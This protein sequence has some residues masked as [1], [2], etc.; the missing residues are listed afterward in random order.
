MDGG[1]PRRN[2][3][4]RVK[5]LLL[6]SMSIFL[7][8]VS[9]CEA[10]EIIADPHITFLQIPGDS[11]GEVSLSVRTHPGRSYQW[12]LEGPGRLIGDTGNPAI[13]YVAPSVLDDTEAAA[14]IRITVAD[15][16]GKKTTDSFPIRLHGSFKPEPVP[17]PFNPI[18]DLLEKAEAA[19]KKKRFTTPESVS[20]FSYYRKVLDEDPEN[21]EA[22]KGIEQ[23]LA[24]YERRIRSAS[25]PSRAALFFNRYKMVADYHSGVSSEPQ[26]KKKMPALIP[27]TNPPEQIPD[28]KRP[29]PNPIVEKTP[30]PSP[31]ASAM[32][33]G[34]EAMAKG[35]LR[36][37]SSYLFK[38]MALGDPAMIIPKL[39][40]LKQISVSEAINDLKAEKYRSAAL[41]YR[42]ARMIRAST[43]ASVNGDEIPADPIEEWYQ[44]IRT[45]IS[46]G[47]RCWRDPDCDLKSSLA[48]YQDALHL[49]PINPEVQK[50]LKLI[51]QAQYQQGE[52]KSFLNILD[53]VIYVPLKSHILQYQNAEEI[54]LRSL[55]LMELVVLYQM[56]IEWLKKYGENSK[57]FISIIESFEEQYEEYKKVIE[58]LT[59]R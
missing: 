19:F 17:A 21:A 42:Y 56:S 5:Y 35:H 13:I 58:S 37:A 26:W 7:L 30:P 53:I 47:D 31:F 43:A 46:D 39:K 54:S 10:I 44:N 50:R 41:K 25:D 55:T 36:S 40:E 8:L 51:S 29:D 15:R 24:T 2:R 33:K 34:E 14:I 9:L 28:K 57:E 16:E 12:R 38:A 32:K 1:F 45:T 48:H 22:K 49:D 18:K 11:P 3:L 52:N 20:A 27:F 6:I 23:I 59:N 4:L